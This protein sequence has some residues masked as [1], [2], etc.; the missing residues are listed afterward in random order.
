MDTPSLIIF[1]HLDEERFNALSSQ[2]DGAGAL[3]VYDKDGLTNGK[4]R[5]VG[6]F[7]LD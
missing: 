1:G 6:V 5:G 7:S 3:L 4:I 2:M